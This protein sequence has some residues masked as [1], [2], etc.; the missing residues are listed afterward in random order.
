ME[1]KIKICIIGLGYVGLPLFKVVSQ[2]FDCQGLDCSTSTIKNIKS[3][4]FYSDSMLLTSDWNVISDCNVFIVCVPTPIKENNEPD[5]SPLNDVCES[6][7]K[8]VKCGDIVIFESTIYPGATEEYCVPILEK[9][10]NLHCN[11]DFFVGYSPERINVGD[12]EHTIE[13]VPKIVSGSNSYAIKVIANVYRTF[14]GDNIVIAPS[15]KVAE[16]AKMYENVQRDV[17]IALANEYADYCRGEEIDI[18]AVTECASSKWNFS[19][20][21]PGLVGG[22][23]ISVDPYYMIAK[24]KR[25]NIAIPL[26][27]TAREVNESKPSKIADRI[28][29]RIKQSNKITTNAK[30]L[31]F[32]FSYKANISDI[33]NTKVY[34]VIK[35][36][37]SRS[38]SCD[39]IDPWVDTTLAKELYGVNVFNHIDQIADEYDLVV[40]LVSHEVFESE[41]FLSL[42]PIKL[43]ELV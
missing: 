21:N 24:A 34:D 35:Y 17:L 5:L 8:V 42:H 13:Q 9:Y 4:D 40:N 3:Q 26:I 1:R 14:L 10:S 38:I 19:I 37:T 30:I 33:R 12:T 6:L 15:I 25:K 11:I 39:C 28:I 23:C 32:G 22:H 16:A 27:T 7:G 2:Y 31:I 36:L 18:D 20:V 43:N 29:D 41:V